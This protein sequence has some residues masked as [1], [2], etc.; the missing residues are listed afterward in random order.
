M[1]S[2]SPLDFNSMPV[3]L[4]QGRGYIDAITHHKDLTQMP[5]I[6]IEVETFDARTDEIEKTIRVDYANVR[7][8]SWLAKHTH[9]ALN[10][11][12]GITICP[13]AA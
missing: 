8:R 5:Q 2:H 3:T 11:G 4:T 9:W 7:D 12:R 1:P 6:P 13:K 10:N